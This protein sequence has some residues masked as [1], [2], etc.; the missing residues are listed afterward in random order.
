MLNRF[1]TLSKS[2]LTPLFLTD[3]IKLDGIPTKIKWKIQA[4]FTF[5]FKF[6]VFMWKDI[7]C[8]YQ[9]FYF[10]FYISSYISRYHVLQLFETS[11]NITWKRFMGCILTELTG[12][13]EYRLV[14]CHAIRNFLANEIYHFLRLFE[15][16][17]IPLHVIISFSYYCLFQSAILHKVLNQRVLK[18]WAYFSQNSIFIGCNIFFSGFGYLFELKFASHTASW[19]F[20]IYI[21]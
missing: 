19:V 14:R 12:D 10:L 21:I 15:Q 8:S 7:R 11:F 2:P 1:W 20:N 13:G 16:R 6:W 5:Y 17:G 4:S 18:F 3:N 9:F